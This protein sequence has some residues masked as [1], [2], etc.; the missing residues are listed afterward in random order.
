[1]KHSPS[2]EVRSHQ[3]V[4]ELPP[5]WNPTVHYRVHKSPLSV[6]ILS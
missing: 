3:L 4:N 2:S 1:M 5:L 6:P